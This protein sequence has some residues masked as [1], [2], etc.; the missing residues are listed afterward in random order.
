MGVLGSGHE[1]HG[2]KRY[3]GESR[4]IGSAHMKEIFLEVVLRWRERLREKDVISAP[5]KAVI[6][7]QKNDKISL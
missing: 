4:A 6:A 3:V 7:F 2:K 1:K 5:V